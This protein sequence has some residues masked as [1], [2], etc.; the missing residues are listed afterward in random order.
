MSIFFFPLGLTVYIFYFSKTFTESSLC[1]LVLCLVNYLFFKTDFANVSFVILKIAQKK[2]WACQYFFV[3]LGPTVH[4]FLLF[5]NLHRIFSVHISFVLSELF[6]FR[7]RFCKCIFCYLENRSKEAIGVSIFFC[8]LGTY[9]TYF[10]FFQ[11]LHRIPKTKCLIAVPNEAITFF[12]S[13]TLY[14]YIS[15]MRV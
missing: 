14:V 2:L 15:E 1:I 7:N 13:P 11:N 5:Q 10:L 9:C 3:S 6:I 8:F 4:I 12:A